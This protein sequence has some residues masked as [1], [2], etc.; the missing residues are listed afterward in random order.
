MTDRVAAIEVQ[1]AALKE[2]KKLAKLEAKFVAEK[3]VGLERVAVAK[4]E[5]FKAAQSSDEY[6]ALV[7]K[8]PPPVAA[9]AKN[10]LSKAREAYRLNHRQPATGAAV[11]SISG[12]AHQG[13]VG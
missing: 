13:E 1:E 5:A 10:K 8:I 2:A 4:A 11:E 9:E 3:Q 7:A 6:E 12:G